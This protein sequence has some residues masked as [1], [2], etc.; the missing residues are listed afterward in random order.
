ARPE[1]NGLAVTASPA[2]VNPAA[3]FAVVEGVGTPR[4]TVSASI[5]S[6]PTAR[7]GVLAAP[8]DTPQ[9][10]VAEDGTWSLQIP[11]PLLSREGTTFALVQGFGSRVSQTQ[12]VTLALQAPETP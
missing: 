2:E 1:L 4:A 3:G 7:A 12:T 10:T 11:V 9:T 6:A 5:T 8:A